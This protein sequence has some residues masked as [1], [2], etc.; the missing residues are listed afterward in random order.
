MPVDFLPERRLNDCL[1]EQNFRM[2]TAM[3]LIGWAFIVGCNPF[4]HSI[5]LGPC[6][7]V[8]MASLCRRILSLA[9]LYC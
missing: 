6:K 3:A 2:G 5:W 7:V 9:V 1:S 4:N 8:L